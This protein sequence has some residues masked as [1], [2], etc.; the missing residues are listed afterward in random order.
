MSA[1][2]YLR[3]KDLEWYDNHKNVII[4][5]ILMLDT[6]VRKSD[7]KIWFKGLESEDNPYYDVRLF[8]DS[9]NSVFLEISWHP[10]SINISLK[11]IFDWLRQET[12]IVIED[13]DGE[14]SGW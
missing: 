5:K 7:N 13:D 14:E 8:L 1:E 11:L 4:R 6:F 12:S 9:K 10:P 3:F 2:F